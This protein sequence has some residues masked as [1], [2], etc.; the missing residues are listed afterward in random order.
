MIPG[1]DLWLPAYIVGGISG[2]VFI[3]VVWWWGITSKK[4]HDV[5]IEDKQYLNHL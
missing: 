4:R 3:I 2:L 5:F 1:S